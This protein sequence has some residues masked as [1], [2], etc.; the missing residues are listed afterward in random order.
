MQEQQ[1][2]GS[3]FQRKGGGGRATGWMFLVVCL[4]EGPHRRGLCA[5]KASGGTP[6]RTHTS[7]MTSQLTEQPAGMLLRKER[8]CGGEEKGDGRGG[9]GGEEEEEK[10]WP[11]KSPGTPTLWDRTGRG[12]TEAD[13]ATK[14]TK[15]GLKEET[16]LPQMIQAVL[17]SRD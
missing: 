11:G 15:T 12:W 8:L 17:T 10:A 1:R 5:G 6:T 14:K 3:V 7:P 13:R 9:K 4:H 16:L 2:E